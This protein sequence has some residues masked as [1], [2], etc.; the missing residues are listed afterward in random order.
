MGWLLLGWGAAHA[1][2]NSDHD[3][4]P[5]IQGMHWTSDPSAQASAKIIAALPPSAW[6]AMDRS[7]SK[8]FTADAV[9][10]RLSYRTPS[11]AT[12]QTWLLE[13]NQTALHEVDFFYT[14]VHG[15][16]VQHS[17]IRKHPREALA[18]DYRR[19]LIRLPEAPQGATV[20]VRIHTQ[21]S[22][23]A[24]VRIWS[25]EDWINSRSSETLW[26]GLFFGSNVLVVVFFGF[27]AYWTRL[28]LHAV[29]ALYM[30]SLLSASVLTGNWQ[31]LITTSGSSYLWLGL[32]GIVLGWINFIA[33]VFDFELLR[34]R[35]SRKRL[36]SIVLWFTGVASAVAT[37]G[38][39]MGHY[40][41]F[42]PISQLI[43][44]GLICLNIYIGISELRKGNPQAKLFLWAFGIFYVGVLI[45]Y[46]R[47]FGVLEPNLIN[48]NSYQVAAFAHMLIMSV[49]IFSGY[50]RMHRE[51][52]AAL[53][54]AKSEQEQ[55]QRQSEFLAL[56]SHELRTPLTV[57]SA[58]AENLIDHKGLDYDGQERVSKIQRAADRMRNIIEGY[59]NAERLSGST[60]LTNKQDFNLLGVCRQA[61]KN[62]Q[63]KKPHPIELQFRVSGSDTMRGDALQIGLAMD[64][65]LNNAI[66]YSLSDSPVIVTVDG[67]HAAFSIC[68]TNQG[69]PIDE[70][71]LPHIFKRF[72]R[73]RN[74]KHCPGSGLGLYFVQ[75]VA[76]THQGYVRAEN[77]PNGH[78]RFTLVLVRE[79][80]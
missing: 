9:W 32:L 47:N 4:A 65:L 15:Q 8:G 43:G 35:E 78:C 58:A 56:V 2:V 20:Y 69:E 36:T 30:L 42:V 24:E 26:W 17:G 76:T 12:P 74:A 54:M 64:N 79:A 44:A 63:E 21:T 10:L 40:R 28:K 23:A 1:L 53:A 31:S 49:G 13:I 67:T 55:R 66:N 3:P 22:L 5:V 39:M 16:W 46:L 61:I 73:G 11:I 29:Y 59:L 38:V 27:Y 34:I 75:L 41:T 6:Q 68:V 80:L 70:L 25:Y 72:Y 18:F 77:L 7:I 37:L 62:A 60:Q 51:R 45:R 48:E 52:N 57:V 14:D 19:P 71:D 33:M 50:N